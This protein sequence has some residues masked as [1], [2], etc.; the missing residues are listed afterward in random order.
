VTSRLYDDNLYKFDT[1][2]SSYWEATAG[3]TRVHAAALSSDESCDV[4]IIGGG[5]TGLS[6][7]LHLARDHSVDVRVLEAGHIGWGASGR[8]GGFCSLGGTGVGRRELVKMVGLD[9]AREFS[10]SQVDAVELVRDLGA[11]EGIEYQAFGSAELDVAHTRRAYE[12]LKKDH[13]LLTRQLGMSAEIFSADECREQF[14]DSSEQYGALLTR[15]T[16]GLHP[17]RFCRGLAKAA[18]RRGAILHERSEVLSWEKSDEGQHLINTAGGTLRAKKVIFSTNG[19]MPEDL[20][21]NFYA[22]TLPVISAIIVT[23]P[24]SE[25]EKAAHAWITE[26]PAINSRRILNYFRLL[27]DNR[28]MFGGRG[29]TT[30]HVEGERETYARLEAMLKKIWPEWSGLT[31]DYGWQGLIAMTGS[32]IPSIG[33]LDADDSVYFGYGYHGNGVNTATWTGKQLA[34]WIG[35]GETPPLPQIVQ[36]MARKYPLAGLRLHYLRAA[37]A[38]SSWRD[39][40]A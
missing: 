26:H 40:R 9:K 28:F 16:F 12:G 20:H 38:F 37:I 25:D 36:G 7:A 33:R 15:P 24:L 21:P 13:E 5:Y 34:D 10:R 11:S 35:S 8:N 18:I 19:F 23:R 29:H 22:R 4:A 39:G 14:F 27:P 6:A 30:G 17:L 31:V 32:L 1:P 3:D 2:Q